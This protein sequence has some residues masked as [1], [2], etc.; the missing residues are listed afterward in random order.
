MALSFFLSQGRAFMDGR[1]RVGL[2]SRGRK[3]AALD[4]HHAVARVISQASN[5]GLLRSLRGV[6]RATDLRMVFSC[7]IKQSARR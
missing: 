7:R 6:W 2:R 3:A 4:G 1:K 5:P